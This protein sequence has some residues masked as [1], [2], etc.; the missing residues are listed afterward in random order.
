M[1]TMSPRSGADRGAQPTEAAAVWG[2]AAPDGTPGPGRA[3]GDARRPAA[4]APL[5]GWARPME[6]L[7]VCAAPPNLRRTGTI[8]LVVG[9]CLVAINQLQPL[10]QGPRTLGV[11]VRVV[12]DF[13]VPFVVSNLGVLS[14]SRRRQPFS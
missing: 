9:S 2:D 12:L 6:A 13:V 3:R 7:R 1:A 10:L 5:S 4:T 11:F 8:A 14:A